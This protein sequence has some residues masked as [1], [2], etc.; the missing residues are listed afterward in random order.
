MIERV[1]MRVHMFKNEWVRLHVGRLAH[2]ARFHSST[3][4]SAVCYTGNDP[5]QEVDGKLVYCHGCNCACHHDCLRLGLFPG[6]RWF[7]ETFTTSIGAAAQSSRRL[8]RNGAESV[9]LPLSDT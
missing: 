7:C 5:S 1:I 4:G 6:R 3:D 2:L 9:N 8:A